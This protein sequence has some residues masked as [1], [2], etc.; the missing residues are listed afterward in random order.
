MQL[1]SAEDVIR[2]GS[3]PVE[4]SRRER[5]GRLVVRAFPTPSRVQDRRDYG[6]VPIRRNVRVLQSP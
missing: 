5:L 3:T 6:T 4:A 2:D 1:A